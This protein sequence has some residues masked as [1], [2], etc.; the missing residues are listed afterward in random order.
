[1]IRRLSSLQRDQLRKSVMLLFVTSMLVATAGVYAQD[2]VRPSLAGQEASDAREQ[3]VSRIP[4]NLLLG[5]VRFRVGATVGV[6]YNDNINYADDGTAVIPNPIGPGF[7]TIRSN[8][9]DDVIV[10]PNLTLDAIW[11]VTQLN[12][13]RLDL[14][15]GY[16]F[17]L[18]HSKNDTD[19][20][21]VAPKSQ[22][23]FDIFVSDFRINI[24]DRMQL[25]QDP[26]QEGALSDVV[27]Y[28][29]F[30]NTA[31][32]SVL[33]DLNK[34]LLQVGYD[35]YNFVSTT[36]RFDYLNRNSEIVQGS[37]A[38]IVNPTITVGAE[39]NAVF[40]RYDQSVLSD[41][42]DYSVGGFVELAL[43]NNLKVRAAGGYQWIDFDHNFVTFAFGPF[44][45][46]VPDQKDLQ[47]YYA[48]GLISHRINAQLKI[49]RAHV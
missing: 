36:N 43:T 22:I 48:N 10:T 9:Q 29:R 40:T 37:A 23:A 44:T 47:D 31:G 5:P 18:D 28:G 39:G 1:M 32:L 25:Q 8:S 42:K 7:I 46:L 14:G 12:T 19:Y 26:I 4:Y 16:A 33:W 45:F 13:L 11:P 30:E 2:A 21:L 35:H 49:G 27:N 41:N 24:H 34:L 3:D 17:Y 38:F 20:I 15:I 6:E